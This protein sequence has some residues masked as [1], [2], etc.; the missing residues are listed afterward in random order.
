MAQYVKAKTDKEVQ[1]LSKKVGRHSVGGA[2]CTGLG[3]QVTEAKTGIFANWVLRVRSKT[4]GAVICRYGRYPD[5][6]LQ[7]ARQ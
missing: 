7:A 4:L 3:L 1:A 5:V 6:S 2:G